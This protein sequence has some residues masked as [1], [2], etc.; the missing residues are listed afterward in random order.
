MY[1]KILIPL[2]NSPTDQAILDHIR[3]LAKMT[4][5]QLILVHVADGFVARLQDQLNLADSQEIR[6]D[7]RYLDERQKELAG[8]GFHVKAILTQ[9]KEPA[10]GILNV[11][12]SEQ[13][14]LIAL[15]THGHRFV[16]DVILGSVANSLRHR[17]DIP[18]MMI[19]AKGQV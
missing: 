15:A 7:Q 13:C 11:A 19:R 18:V 8:E 5:A 12:Q 1:R 14:D 4:G 17:T 9:G 3:P 16:Q 2:D 10:D 6:E